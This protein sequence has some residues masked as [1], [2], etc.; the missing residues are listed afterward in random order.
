M[1]ELLTFSLT[2]AV[3]LA[4]FVF[5]GEFRLDLWLYFNSCMALAF[6]CTLC[7]PLAEGREGDA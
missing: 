1:R 3:I 7:L 2:G 5:L 4:P 6:I